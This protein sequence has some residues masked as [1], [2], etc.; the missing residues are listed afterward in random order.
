[1]IVKKR[2]RVN[3][4]VEIIFEVDRSDAERIALVCNVEEWRPTPMRRVN[5]GKG[6]FRA[7][8]VLGTGEEAHFRYLVDGEEWLDEPGA[9]GYVSNPYGGVNA[10]VR[11]S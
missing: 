1:M 7:K 4:T 6:P 10:V 9:D 8:L 2:H 5:R 3:N 11:A